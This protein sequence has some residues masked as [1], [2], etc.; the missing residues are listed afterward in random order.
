MGQSFRCSD[1]R[2]GPVNSGATTTPAQI[3]RVAPSFG[4][5]GPKTTPPRYRRCVAFAEAPSGHPQSLCTDRHSATHV[6][7]S[8]DPILPSPLHGGVHGERPGRLVA[9]RFR[10]RFRARPS[11]P[12]AS[13]SVPPQ[14]PRGRRRPGPRPRP[15][16][17]PLL[18][19]PGLLAAA[20]PAG[21]GVALLLE[22]PPPKLRDVHWT[23]RPASVRAPC[24]SPRHSSLHSA[25]GAGRVPLR[26]VGKE[27]DA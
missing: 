1:R 24:S 10:R 15:W 7:G 19:R 4:F 21:P 13:G 16:T 14:T 9:P 3:G 18:R 5:L 26:A 25:K 27:P 20:S 8:R 6:Q 22:S 23:Q 12:P 2:T 17:G 11:Q